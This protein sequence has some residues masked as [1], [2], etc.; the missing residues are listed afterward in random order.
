MKTS[1]TDKNKGMGQ[2]AN[3]TARPAVTENLRP[4][5]GLG[6]VEKP[7]VALGQSTSVSSSKVVTLRPAKAGPTHEQI[8]ERAHDIWMRN[9]RPLGLDQANWLEAEA[10]LMADLSG[11]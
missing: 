10:Q 3:S 11:K 7:Q 8:A 9:G 2:K 6:T 5:A 4:S 1:K